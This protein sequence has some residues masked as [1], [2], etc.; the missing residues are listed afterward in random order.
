[1]TKFTWLILTCLLLTG[2]A[3]ERNRSVDYGSNPSSQI[4]NALVEQD[5]STDT[6]NDAVEDTQNQVDEIQT[7]TATILQ[8]EE[9]PAGVEEE[10]YKIQEHSLAVER[11]LAIINNQVDDID[12]AGDAIHAQTH[13]VQDQE[14]KMRRLLSGGAEA[15]KN[16]YD[17]LRWVFMLGIAVI[18]GGA[19][20]GFYN[21]RL[22]IMLAG[23]GL[24]TT[25]IA[26]AMI[27]YLEVIALG[28]I[29][30]VA[31]AAA[32]VIFFAARALYF[33]RVDKETAESSV[34][35]I[36]QMKEELPDDTKAK[37]FGKGAT[38][39]VAEVKQN[40]RVKKRVA[41]V[42]RRKGLYPTDR[43][44]GPTTLNG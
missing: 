14:N 17:D 20:L 18:I 36:E 11:N 13:V 7:S 28:G 26:A 6:I 8:T 24:I 41:Q 31:I 19:L 16:I 10:T 38:I 35:L 44:S 23:A 15:R 43:T 29:I 27:Y 22:G 40:E 33:G 3:G 30:V 39:G 42:R 25:G 34:E 21:P 12:S 5:R 32:A 9:L 2:C 1:M 4:Q 37:V